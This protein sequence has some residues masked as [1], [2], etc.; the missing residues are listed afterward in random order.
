MRCV[1]LPAPV[2]TALLVSVRSA[3]EARAALEGG[4]DWIDLKDPARGAL[5]AVD[6]VVARQAAN[7]IAGRKPVSAAAG[8]LL[9]WAAGEARGLLNVAGLSSMKLGLAGCRALDWRPLWRR[10]QGELAAAGVELAAVAYAD[11]DAAESPPI[12][13]V[14]ELAA[15]CNCRWLLVDTYDKTGQA[16]TE[17]IDDAA[18][19]GAFHA[20]RRRG[21]RT[22]AAGR[23]RAAALA[24]LPLESID[25][26]GVRS[27]A[28]SGD[29]NGDVSA[30]D[31]ARLH[32]LLAAADHAKCRHKVHFSRPR[33]FA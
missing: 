1:E 23:L 20:A 25:M 28:C 11:S 33:E 26:I 21:C 19:A 16:L 18:L 31:V 30:A 6:E 29:R 32:S 2:R 22:V 10:A 8:E 5:G 13:E 7:V 14:V 12:A 4:A 24:A 9:D 15:S 27:A 3:D 17:L